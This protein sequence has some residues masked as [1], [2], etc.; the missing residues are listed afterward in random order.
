MSLVGKDS[1]VFPDTG[2]FSQPTVDGRVGLCL[3]LGYTR[4]VQA[5]SSLRPFTKTPVLL[6]GRARLLLLLL[7][8]AI[9]G[10]E[11][12]SND[13]PVSSP[14]SPSATV[15]GSSGTSSEGVEDQRAESVP[16][17]PTTSKALSETLAN[18]LVRDGEQRVGLESLG[19]EPRE[20]LIYAPKVGQEA[21]RELVVE[22]NV[23]VGFA[24][25]VQPHVEAVPRL[26]LRL[27]TKLLDPDPKD[28]LK[29]LE[30][31]VT[32]VGAE[33]EGEAEKAIARKMQGTLDQLASISTVLHFD[34]RGRVRDAA[35]PSAKTAPEVL[36]LY[37]SVM[38]ALGETI[39]VM[40]RQAVGK[41]A[42]WNVLRRLRR[43]GVTM[44]RLS[45]YEL[46]QRTDKAMTITATTRELP[47]DSG[48]KDPAL[49]DQ[50][51][52][53]LSAGT[54]GGSQT[55]QR[56]V[57]AVVPSQSDSKLISRVAMKVRPSQEVGAE[58][59]ESTVRIEQQFSLGPVVNEF[60]S[61]PGKGADRA[62]GTGS[63]G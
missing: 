31:R 37:G 4:G 57:G 10:C 11:G 48:K 5:S 30:V 20:R 46:K 1:S 9:A 35:G 42:R 32:A 17:W 51:I 55:L 61:G 52:L 14:S 12:C 28:D 21:T 54:S 19:A 18:E 40:P 47:V 45:S 59:V 16:D 56:L 8:L 3:S 15:S 2:I 25:A 24:G 44:I 6:H 58:P 7:C 39:I 53:K 13:D 27:A 63:G 34:D 23:M 29:A 50:V 22:L 41:G 38:E 49:A 62:A 43:A 36:Q 60:G 26:R 33:P